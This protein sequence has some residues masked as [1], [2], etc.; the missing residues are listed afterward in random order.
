MILRRRRQ[1][2]AKQRNF[3]ACEMHAGSSPLA[4]RSGA[5]TKNTWRF[6]DEFR[7][8]LGVQR[9]HAVFFIRVTER[10][11]NL[12]IQTKIRMRQVFRLY[13]ARNA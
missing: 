13:H 8:L 4:P 11:N 1:R 9:H 3:C 7:L 5:R 2:G 6:F 10:R 12:T